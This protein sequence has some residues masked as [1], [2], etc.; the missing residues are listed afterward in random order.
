ML[1][2]ACVNIDARSR[3]PE[4]E[5]ICQSTLALAGN[6]AGAGG[7]ECDE[8]AVGIADKAMKGDVRVFELPGDYAEIIDGDGD[9][10]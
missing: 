10:Y 5:T 7:I 8:G 1:Y 2:T 6:G 4:I 9:G 3:S